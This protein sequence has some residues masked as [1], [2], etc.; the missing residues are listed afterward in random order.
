[1]YRFPSKK[2]YEFCISGSIRFCLLNISIWSLRISGKKYYNLNIIGVS[3]RL[4]V[5]DAL[6]Y[7]R[8]TYETVIFRKVNSEN[9]FLLL[10]NAWKRDH[11]K[12]MHT[13]AQ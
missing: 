8:D 13:L 6:N 12:T 11:S 9:K 3:N 10:Y 7:S 4:F 2:S 1:V 5:S